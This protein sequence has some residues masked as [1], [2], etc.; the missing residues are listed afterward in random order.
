MIEIADHCSA[1]PFYK[2]IRGVRVLPHEMIVDGG[3]SHRDV[4]RARVNL[5]TR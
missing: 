5:R 1:E 2:S 4:H 3:L